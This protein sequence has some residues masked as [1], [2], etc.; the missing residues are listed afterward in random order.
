MGLQP[1]RIYLKRTTTLTRS[2]NDTTT[3]LMLVRS[4]RRTWVPGRS[5]S[6]SYP[7]LRASL[8]VRITPHVLVTTFLFGTS[9]W[10]TC[11]FANSLSRMMK[12]R[13]NHEPDAS[14][15]TLS[16]S[17]RNDESSSFELYEGQTICL[18]WC[19]CRCRSPSV[20]SFHS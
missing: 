1:E 8:P 20:Q 4:Y 14:P 10:L 16:M 18:S 13:T 9:S 11:L 12:S 19:S 15:T 2:M 17:P 3:D 6:T 5:T 7:I